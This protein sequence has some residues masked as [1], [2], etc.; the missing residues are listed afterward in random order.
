M[1][2]VIGIF[3]T[4]FGSLAITLHKLEFQPIAFEIV[5]WTLALGLF[6]IF[7]MLLHE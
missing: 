7:E 1:L 3:I 2:F 5:C 4:F 6:L